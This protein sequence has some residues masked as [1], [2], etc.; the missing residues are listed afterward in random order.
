MRSGLFI[1]IVIAIML[2]AG[3]ILFGGTLFASHKKDAGTLQKVELL[4]EEGLEEKQ[5]DK[6]KEKTE[7]TEEME[8]ENEKPPDAAEIIHNIELSP[9]SAPALEAASLSDIEA[10]LSGQLGKGGD[11]S[12]ALSFSSGGRIGGTGKVNVLEQNLDNAFNLSEID[13]KPQAIF[14]AAPVYPAS[15]HSVEGVVSL[16]FVVDKTGKVINPRVEKSSHREFEKP[17]IDAV[18]QWKFEPAVKGGQRVS[19][20][21]HV[22]IR[23]QPR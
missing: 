17:A 16:F 8:T 3:V 2:H 18:K 9:A 5:K 12:S 15:M 10:A 19:C 6:P 20:K 11:F 1:G 4:S 23:F 14:Q 13:Q 21:M 22:P 7:K